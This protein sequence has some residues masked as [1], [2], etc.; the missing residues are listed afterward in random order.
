LLIL[1]AYKRVVDIV[2]MAIDQE[3]V[4]G[5]QTGL[6]QTIHAGLCLT[7]PDGP[8]ICKELSHESRE[9]A[10]IREELTKK[11]ER[12]R[13]ASRELVFDI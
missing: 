6:E 9:V 2:A 7:G 12:L 13:K 10:S 3:L 11:R 5:L 1:V 8:R 4:R